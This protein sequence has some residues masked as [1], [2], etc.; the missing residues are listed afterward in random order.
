MNSY[1][2]KEKGV[3]VYAVLMVLLSSAATVYSSFYMSHLMDA[4]Y[5]GN[6]GAIPGL[7]LE[8]ILFIA[9]FTISDYLC[10]TSAE[11]FVQTCSR[12]VREDTFSRV[13]HMN[14]NTFNEDTSAKYISVLNNDMTVIEEK[15]LAGIPDIIND[16]ALYVL[17]VFC[18]VLF[19]A[20]AR[21]DCTAD[22]PFADVRAAHYG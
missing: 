11:K 13:L 12:R 18:A 10:R 8:G 21:G 22:K 20:A 6:V 15:Y 1:I 9:V 4:V 3:L 14:I 17:A 16:I 5:A 19:L 7:I 2:R